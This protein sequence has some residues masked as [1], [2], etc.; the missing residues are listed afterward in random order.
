MVP[1]MSEKPL[2]LLCVGNFGLD[3]CL[4]GTQ[5]LGVSPGGAA[6]RGTLAAALFGVPV[7][8]VTYIG[9]EAEWKEVVALLTR[10][11]I[12]ISGIHCSPTS[13]SF[14]NYY[15]DELHIDRVEIHNSH[16][17]DQLTELATDESINRAWLVAVFPLALDDQYA[18]IQRTTQLSKPVALILHFSCVTPENATEYLELM[19]QVDY[20]FL[21]LLEAELL[22]GE[23]DP[24][25]HAQA[26]AMRVRRAVVLTQGENGCWLARPNV[27]PVHFCPAPAAVYDVTGAGDMLA[28]GVLAGVYLG[29][30]M[31]AA[32]RFGQLVAAL[33]LSDL[34]NRSVLSFL[35]NAPE[36]RP[37][38]TANQPRAMTMQSTGQW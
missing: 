17:M 20:L 19:T 13:A 31:M 10:L 6:L 35:T 25:E 7:R 2:P 28:G 23:G 8:P 11:G 12:D 38:L 34:V 1:M 37:S 26:L 5:Y 3:Y 21:N 15:D 22:L 14:H 9:P 33:S 36:A 30:D 24:C 16:V 27:E 18:L 29:V 32:V 4:V